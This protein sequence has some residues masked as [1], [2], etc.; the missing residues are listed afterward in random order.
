M[1]VLRAKTMVKALKENSGT[2]VKFKVL[3]NKEHR[4]AIEYLSNDKVL[5]FLFG[6]SYNNYMY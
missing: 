3:K 2:S 1:P 6:Y 5:I 4:D